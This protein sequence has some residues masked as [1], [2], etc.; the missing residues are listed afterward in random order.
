MKPFVFIVAIVSAL[1]LTTSAQCDLDAV[2]A[3][4]NEF[5]DA[6]NTIINFS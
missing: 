6:V 5:S 4:S 1:V 2:L 3:C